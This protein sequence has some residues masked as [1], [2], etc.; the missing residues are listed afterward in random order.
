MQ[1]DIYSQMLGEDK[2]NPIEELEERNQVL[3]RQLEEKTASLA[4]A[5]AKIDRL[6]SSDKLTGLYNR[7]K[8]DEF[9]E[10]EVQRSKRYSNALSVILIDMDHFKAVNDLFGHLVGDQ[11]LV[12]I[13]QLISRRLRLTDIVGR[14]TGEEFIIICP[15]TDLENAL[16]LA[17]DLRFL[18]EGHRFRVIG[19]LTASLGVSTYQT[20]DKVELLVNRADRALYAAKS[21]GRNQ[22]FWQQF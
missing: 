4:A 21:K 6:D 22:V 9:L 15:E 8:I 19:S 20:G 17:E 10:A 18:I 12:E 2:P 13:A 3:K 5:Q 7:L 14:W 16:Y 11:V 1:E